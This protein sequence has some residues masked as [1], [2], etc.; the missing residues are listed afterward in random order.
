MDEVRARLENDV[1]GLRVEVERLRKRG[2]L[3]R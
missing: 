3:R 1:H 2:L